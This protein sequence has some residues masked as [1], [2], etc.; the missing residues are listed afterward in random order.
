M[1]KSHPNTEYR[2]KVFPCYHPFTIKNLTF[3]ESEKT[4]KD[5]CER[6]QYEP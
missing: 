2:M 1:H 3:A 4:E 5:R 6:W